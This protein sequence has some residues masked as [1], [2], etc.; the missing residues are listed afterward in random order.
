MIDLQYL[1]ARV[2]KDALRQNKIELDERKRAEGALRE[3]ERRFGDT[4]KNLQ[5]IAAMCDEKSIITFCNDY[6]LRLTGWERD[7]TVGRSWFEMFIPEHEQ[8][9][10]RTIVED[11]MPDGSVIPH[12]VNEIRTRFG[13]HRLV[14]W[15]NTTSHDSD[16]QFIG[17]F[18]LGDDITDRERMEQGLRES[19]ERYRHLVENAR[20]IIYTHDLEGNY[21]SI[22]RAGE[23]IT[24]YTR[25]ETLQTNIAQTIAPEYLKTARQMIARKMAGEKITAYELEVQ[26]MVAK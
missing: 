6:L 12:F 5:M 11:V 18:A 23:Q 19:E 13:E 3:S 9:R 4:L 16:S 21:T 1:A 17:L 7:E 8:K 15:T 25:E 14:K 10:V 20:D 26:K 2:I 24:G 22:N